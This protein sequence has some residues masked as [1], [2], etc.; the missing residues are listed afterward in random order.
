MNKTAA[1]LNK[2]TLRDLCEQVQYGY[3]ASAESEG[4]GPKFL[5]ITDIV[6]DLIEWDTVPYCN[7][8]D[9][10][11]EKYLLSEGDIVIARTGAT[12]GYAKY[13]KRPPDAVFASYLVRLKLKDK[14]NKR[15]IGFIVESDEY[16]RFILSNIGGAAQPN[17][18]AQI[19]TSFHLP[20]P[21]LR[22]Q[23][24]I[25]SILSAYDDLIENNSR[26][27]K[28]L[29]EMAQ[30]IYKEWFVN[31]R[32]PRH[33][34]VKMVKSK[35]GMI[36][37]GWEV[38]KI[39]ELLRKIERR[40]RVK[41]V[42]YLA[43][44]AIPVVDQGSDFIGGYTNEYDA[45]HDNP[46]P[47]IVFGDHTRIIKYI[48]FP[49]ASG[50]DGTQ[51]LYPKNEALMP[52][53]FYYVVMNVDL[54]NFA[55]ARHFKFLKDKEVLIPGISTL[56]LF[57]ENVGALLKQASILRKRNDNLRKTRD[58]LLPKLISGEIDVENKS[59]H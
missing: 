12:T 10:N 43:Q 21:P 22:T 24:K 11:V 55:Y 7:I 17:A 39:G 6:P 57:N 20:L 27:I 2:V 54:S 23:N 51:L 59:R 50:A 29:E 25:A 31:F 47:I 49:F 28:I 4:V 46:L 56:K 1:P 13:I 34:K 48:D 18:N 58:L 19:L 53:Y 15:F 33:K 38:V 37:D 30:A 5:R 9:E 35:L 45:L 3:T 26:R 32:F 40:P 36:P 42:D 14:V 52:A 16:K 41:K 44:G 8:D